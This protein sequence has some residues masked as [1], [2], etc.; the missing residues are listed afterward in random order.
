MRC[1]LRVAGAAS[2]MAAANR[3]LVQATKQVVEGHHGLIR[4]TR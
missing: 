2:E 3:D 1:A 4:L